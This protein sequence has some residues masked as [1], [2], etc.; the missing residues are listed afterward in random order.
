M[1][2]FTN[3]GILDTLTQRRDHEEKKCKDWRA[4]VKWFSKNIIGKN[5]K[6]KK[7]YKL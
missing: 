3:M 4:K 1:F 2:T 6:F 7:T 5:R